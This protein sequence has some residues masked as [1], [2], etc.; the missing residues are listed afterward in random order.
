MQGIVVRLHGR[1]AYVASDGREYA[2]EMR[3]KMKQGRRESR[4]PIAVGDR[5]EISVI[6]GDDASVESVQPRKGELVRPSTRDPRIKQVIAANVENLAIVVSADAINDSLPTLDRLLACAFM[7]NLTP[8]IVVNKVDLVHAPKGLKAYRKLPLNMLFVSATRGDGL[9][10]LRALLKG[11][12]SVFAG[13]SGVGK[14]SLLN[15]L[16]PGLD[17]R[18]NEISRSGD[19]KHTTTNASLVPVAG[20]WVVDTPG[21]REF[22]LWELKLEELSLFYPD[23]EEFRLKCRFSGCTHRHEP[24]CAV[25]KAVE[26]GDLDKGRYDRY[27]DLLRESWN[28]EQRQRP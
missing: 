12:V 1:I 3:G 28:A 8:A 25:K 17:I 26:A 23:F 11:R 6:G 14:S 24:G 22:G 15:A 19:G 7:Q 2:C 9:D 27:L 20:G 4:S 13:L 10:D 5:V 18:T 16:E 21:V